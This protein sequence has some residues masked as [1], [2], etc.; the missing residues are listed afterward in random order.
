M[1]PG[2]LKIS[3]IE[4]SN[5]LKGLMLLIRKDHRITETENILL[6]RIGKSL[7]FDP[8]F[9][10]NTIKDILNNKYVEDSPPVFSNKELAEKFIKDGLAVVFSDNN[11]HPEEENWLIAVAEKNGISKVTYFE[12]KNK[13]SGI[14][15][16][17]AKLE[18]ED[19]IVSQ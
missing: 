16:M 5:Y 14:D 17:L 7:G 6:M 13:Y 1:L 12:Y 18:V 10:E 8:E 19:L 11:I 3:K 9:C 4:A 15:T 2:P